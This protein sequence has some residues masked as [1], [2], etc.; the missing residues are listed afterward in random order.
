M[1]V[2]MSY[3]PPALDPPSPEDS[4]YSFLSRPQCH[5]AAGRIRRIEKSSDLIR[6]WTRDIPACSIVPQ[7]TYATAC[8]RTYV[9]ENIYSVLLVCYTEKYFPCPMLKICIL[10]TIQSLFP[11]SELIPVFWH[12]GLNTS[13]SIYRRLIGWE[14]TVVA[15]PGTEMDLCGYYCIVLF[16]T[17]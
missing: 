1:A 14:A 5:R 7:P 6:N 8:P 15:T 16:R 13:L 12:Y 17:L 9:Y 4:W 2:R 10:F 3:A 11:P